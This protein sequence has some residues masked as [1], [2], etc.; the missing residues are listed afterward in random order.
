MPQLKQFSL[1]YIVKH[2]LTRTLLYVCVGLCKFL[3][4]DMQILLYQQRIL[5]GTQNN[6]TTYLN[7]TQRNA[8]SN[9]ESDKKIETAFIWMP[10]NWS[11]TNS[12]CERR[13]ENIFNTISLLLSYMIV[14]LALTDCSSEFFL[15][16]QISPLIFATKNIIISRFDGVFSS[17]KVVV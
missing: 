17:S 9:D 10:A 3:S 14:A 13:E 4:I 5:V 16:L 8:C 7:A 6:L 1:D 12:M 2:S 11:R 15:L